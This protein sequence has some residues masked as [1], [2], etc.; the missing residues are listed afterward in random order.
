MRNGT[1]V[2][3]YDGGSK[4][5]EMV[6]QQLHGDRILRLPPFSSRVGDFAFD[7]QRLV[8]AA[9]P[10]AVV[11]VARLQ[12]D[13]AAWTT[14]EFPRTPAGRCG[15][16]V[17]S[18]PVRRATQS[19]G[20]MLSLTCPAAAVLGCTGGVGL[21][22]GKN[23]GRGLAVGS[24]PVLMPPDTTRRVRVQI[25]HRA[26]ARL[27]HDGRLVVDLISGAA[28]RQHDPSRRL[29]FVLLAQRG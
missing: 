17:A 27:R 10:C 11:W 12:F 16:A 2:W 26:L 3:T 23:S 9:Q 21:S 20:V 13:P 14:S 19:G 5:T 25:R 15:T 29:R 22:S 8:W 7:G 4:G 28:G 24:T 1:I 18:V 6:F